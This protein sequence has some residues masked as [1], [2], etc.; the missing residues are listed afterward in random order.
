MDLFILTIIILLIFL[1]SMIFKQKSSLKRSEELSQ[2]FYFNDNT[3][4]IKQ[5]INL[6]SSNLIKDAEKK[7]REMILLNSK[8]LYHHYLLGCILM[9]ESNLSEALQQF[10]IILELMPALE[11]PRKRMIECYYEMKDYEKTIG[12][13]ET[14]L[15][16]YNYSSEIFEY[17][18][19]LADSYFQTENNDKAIETYI[20]LLSSN[21]SNIEYLNRLSILFLRKNEPEKTFEI[22]KRILAMNNIHK[23]AV[24][25]TADFYFGREDYP[26]ALEFL[27]TYN[28]IKPEDETSLKIAQCFYHM[29]RM[30][31]SRAI[32]TG[33]LRKNPDNID[34]YYL[35]IKIC[36]AQ[37]CY[38]RA[39]EYAK[40]AIGLSKDDEEETKNKKTVSSLLLDYGKKWLEKD[41]QEISFDYF[42]EA[43]KYDPENSEV[44]YALAIN[45]QYAKDYEKAITMVKKA[46]SFEKKAKYYLLLGYLFD[47]ENNPILSRKSF[48]DVLRL[49]PNNT[50]A[51]SFLGIF[52]A[53]EKKY[54]KAIELFSDIIKIDKNNQDAYYNIA[55]CYEYLD[56]K[57]RAYEY[58]KKLLEI[59]PQHLGAKNNIDILQWEKIDK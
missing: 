32:A 58:Y 39:I 47:E 55:L 25:R 54:D 37:S 45:N 38:E 44:Y 16:T 49:E 57:V 7:A 41:Q 33:L 51:M 46:L 3:E 6:Y 29:N 11:Y 10:K 12:E 20:K 14:Y 22:D 26:K 59:N 18:N 4:E 50:E 28:K 36:K 13:C 2:H 56:N 17:K 5:I 48:E 15:R 35:L 21:T 42:L 53:Q 23:E 8:N 43:L 24:K 34:I 1:T 52:Y 19:L 30:M 31:D 27:E 40:E 9:K